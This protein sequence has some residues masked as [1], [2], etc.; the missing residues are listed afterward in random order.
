MIYLA[1]KGA[2]DHEH[3]VYVSQATGQGECSVS[4]KHSHPVY[5]LQGE[6]GVEVLLG[7]VE[8]HTH[9]VTPGLPEEEASIEKDKDRISEVVQ[10]FDNCYANEEYSRTR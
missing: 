5:M 9:A 4:D 8:E 3:V 1:Q 7:E 2:L 6:M 10:L